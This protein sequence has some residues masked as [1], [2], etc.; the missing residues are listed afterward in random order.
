MAGGELFYHMKKRH[1]VDE[2]TAKYYAVEILFGLEYLHSNKIIYRDLKPENI[3][4]TADGHLR[5]TDF[6]LSK[7]LRNE[8]RAYTMCGTPEYLAPEVVLSKDGYSYSCDFWSL[9]CVIYEML[10]GFPPFYSRDR[11]QMFRNRLKEEIPFTK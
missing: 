8:D 9:G 1:S 4:V 7:V 6:G 3:L 10:I 2:Y 11:K 5:L